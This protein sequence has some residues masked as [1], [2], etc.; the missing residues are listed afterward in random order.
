MLIEFHGHRGPDE[1]IQCMSVWMPISHLGS[2]AVYYMTDQRIAGFYFYIIDIAA[3]KTTLTNYE[4]LV[5]CPSQNGT[6][7]QKSLK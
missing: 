1:G 6:N 3:S 4:V 5:V 7:K 2:I